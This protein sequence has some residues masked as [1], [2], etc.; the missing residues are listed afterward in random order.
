[1]ARNISGMDRRCRT[2][3][4]VQYQVELYFI[5]KEYLAQQNAIECGNIKAVYAVSDKVFQPIHANAIHVPENT[6]RFYPLPNIEGGPSWK[7]CQKRTAKR[8]W[9]R[10]ILTAAL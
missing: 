6:K 7:L 3:N 8:R 4:T 1:M 10:W 5:R 2:E 9:L